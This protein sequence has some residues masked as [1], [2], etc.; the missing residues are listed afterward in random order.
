M[1]SKLTVKILVLVLGTGSV[2]GVWKA[3]NYNQDKRENYEKQIQQT[4]LQNTSSTQSLAERTLAGT[5][6][7]AST[8][9]QPVQSETNMNAQTQAE[10]SVQALTQVEP[11]VRVM[12][13]VQP[14]GQVMTQ[15]Q[16]PQVQAEKET[17]E[18]KEKEYNK[19]K[20]DD[21]YHDDERHE[22]EDDD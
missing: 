9:V 5:P 6:A 17:Y 2:Y 8:S 14:P 3:G 19:N 11:N 7:A 10:P 18:K 12:T 20:Q 16:Q 15:V 4:I 21:E 1:V 22:E 13:P